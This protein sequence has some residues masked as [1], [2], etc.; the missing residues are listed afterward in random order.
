MVDRCRGELMSREIDRHNGACWE[1]IC[2]LDLTQSDVDTAND[3]LEVNAK[4]FPSLRAKLLGFSS[5][6][7][8][9]D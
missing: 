4:V 9:R 2:N 6:D 1:T 3:A 7:P 8:M 5:H